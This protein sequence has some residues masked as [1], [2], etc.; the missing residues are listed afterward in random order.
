MFCRIFVQ[1]VAVSS[2]KSGFKPYSFFNS[3]SSSPISALRALRSLSGSGPPRWRSRFPNSAMRS[4][5]PETSCWR[6][7]SP[8]RL[9]ANTVWTSWERGSRRALSLR[10][11]TLSQPSQAQREAPRL[12]ILRGRISCEGS[13]AR[14]RIFSQIAR[15]DP[16]CSSGKSRSISFSNAA[17][18]SSRLKR[19]TISS[20]GWVPRSVETALGSNRELYPRLR[21]KL[22]S[23]WMP[24]SDR[25]RFDNAFFREFSRYLFVFLVR[26]PLRSCALGPTFLLSAKGS[27]WRVPANKG[28]LTPS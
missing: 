10:G 7:V 13:P 26:R 20:S 23:W 19:K 3:F 9:E 22:T 8:L 1:G 27:Y 15:T 17:K 25:L 4:N 2:V 14:L 21:Q 12:S 18:N 11:G 6:A 16:L 24:S 28:V 5:I